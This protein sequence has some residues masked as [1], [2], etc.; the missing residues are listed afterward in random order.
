MMRFLLALV[1]IACDSQRAEE[2]VDAGCG[3]LPDTCRM[4]CPAGLNL[5][6]CVTDPAPTGDCNAVCGARECC[7]CEAQPDESWSWRRT[8]VDC[9]PYC[10]FPGTYAMTFAATATGDCPADVLDGLQAALG[11]AGVGQVVIDGDCGPISGSLS[12]TGTPRDCALEVS[13]TGDATPGGVENGAATLTASCAD[14]LA[15]THDLG[16]TFTRP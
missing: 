7:A 8:F 10:I 6:E 15:C 2:S 13:F 4:E 12:A 1:L 9:I 16:V 5:T 3:A 11:D 14:G